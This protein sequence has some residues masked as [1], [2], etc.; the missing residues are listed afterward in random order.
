[1]ELL[2]PGLILVALMV[3]AST[4]IKKTAAA[5]FEPE[6]IETDKFVIEKPE[7]FLTVLNG[8][9]SLEYEGYSKEFGDD[10]AEDIK[11][12][13]IEVRSF[14]DSKL[15]AAISRIKAAT[16]VVSNISEVIGEKKYA[17]IEAETT[18]KNIGML[19]FYKIAESGGG[20]LEL[21]VIALAET[22]PE[23]AR[24]IE[25]VVASFLVK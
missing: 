17:L 6:S 11:Q 9:A 20:V 3:Y 23:V 18:N 10:G 16:K 5:A 19:E 1:M 7:G 12:A 24:K 21:K 13:R 2:I 14:S 4:R 22:N 15:V 25:T 8:D